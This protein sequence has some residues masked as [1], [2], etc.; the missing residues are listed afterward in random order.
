[1]LRD[2]FVN[3]FFWV[4]IASLLISGCASQ[5]QRELLQ[6]QIAV[7]KTYGGVPKYNQVYQ[8]FQRCVTPQ[9]LAQLRRQKQA[10][11]DSGGLAQVDSRYGLYTQ[12]LSRAAV[13]A[14][15]EAYQRATQA[16]ADAFKN[17]PCIA[18]GMSERMGGQSSSPS[19]TTPAPAYVPPVSTPS[20]SAPTY[21]STTVDWDWDWD[22]Q[23]ANGQWVCRGIQTGQYAVP[24][25]CA[26]DIKD[27]NRWPG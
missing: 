5:E 10:C 21:P 12:C 7:C 15:A 24:D 16:A 9:E 8:K 2:S 19:Y 27:D 13:Q 3:K 4:C 25:R 26:M 14:Q 11:I 1:M 6:R 17:A 22:Y 18:C 20:T 23:P